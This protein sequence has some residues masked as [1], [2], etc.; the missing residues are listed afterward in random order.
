[1]TRT[2]VLS[3]VAVLCLSSV[4]AYAGDLFYAFHGA[5]VDVP[6]TSP[7]ASTQTASAIGVYDGNAWITFT[8]NDGS[9]ILRRYL[10]PND[11]SKPPTAVYTVPNPNAPA[12]V[13]TAAPKTVACTVPGMVTSIN[14]GCVPPNHPLA[15]HAS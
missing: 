8:C 3:L 10:N 12:P 9:V 5:F 14:G 2:T 1:M 13:P 7:C 11:N 4:G 15:P 6:L